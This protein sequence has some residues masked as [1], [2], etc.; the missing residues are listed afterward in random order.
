MGAGAP[1]SPHS[2]GLAALLVLGVLG[3]ACGAAAPEPPAPAADTP[4]GP[5]P[6]ETPT[7]QATSP[8]A[9]EAR[10]IQVRASAFSFEPATIALE[11]GERV[12]LEI[13]SL[14]MGHTFTI[15][16]LG[17][18]VRVG[19]GETVRVEFQ[20]ESQGRFA[21]YCRVSGHRREGMEGA[22]IVGQGGA[23]SPATATPGGA[24]DDYGYPPG[25]Y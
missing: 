21:F 14:D 11:P 22:L 12:V 13:S 24:A 18:D 3:A 23:A 4:A 7:P 2:L 19:G 6:T 20:P 10:V 8:P 16:E 17:L 1:P 25:D 9:G 5:S 15:D